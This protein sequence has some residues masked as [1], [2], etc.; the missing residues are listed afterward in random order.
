MPKF[1]NWITSRHNPPE[2]ARLVLPLTAASQPQ[3]DRLG[4]S[5]TA[6]HPLALAWIGYHDA[7]W[8]CKTWH[9]TKAMPTGKTVKIGAFEAGRFIGAVVF[10][11]GATPRIGS[12]YG[13]QQVEVCE[14]TR[15]ALDN[16][17]A[18]VTQIIS[19]ALAMLKALNP[20]LRLVISYAALEEGHHGGIYQAGNW[21]YEDCVASHAFKD[22]D[23]LVHGRTM[24]LRIKRLGMTY[25]EY[26]KSLGFEQLP[27][28]HLKRHK[29]LMP[30]D[31][32]MR[33]QIEP[34]AKEYPDALP[35]DEKEVPA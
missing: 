25:A 22:G 6:K 17:K 21:I 35:Q 23:K 34:L 4:K 32:K 14:L 7:L 15:V 1:R 24:S 27:R 3:L 28:V 5:D 12:P 9:Y 29:Y 16:H 20:G 30:L 18:P 11:R 8:A 33:R 2:E 19:E 13:L 10:S 26:A 31:R